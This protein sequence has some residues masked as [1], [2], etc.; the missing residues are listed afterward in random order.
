[1]SNRYARV[2][3]AAGAAVLVAALGVPVALA[4]GT[5]TVQPGG[6]IQAMSGRLAVKD[7]ATGTVVT[8]VSSSASG[9]LRN[10]SGLP[11]FHAGSL[12]AV[13]S[14]QCDGPGGPRFTLQAGGLPWHLNFT[15][16][17]AAKG[18]AQGTIGKIH[19]AVSGCASVIIDGTGATAHDGRV[20]F[21]YADSTGRLKVLTAGGNLHF[22]GTNGCLGLFGNGDPATF[23]ATYTV[24]PK[25]AI[26]S[27]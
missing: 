14:V 16:Y 3:T 26:T 7:T 25:Q 4:A 1:M 11:G 12:S 27:P 20:A 18:V 24:S 22:Y 15:T 21:R 6:G 5:W 2:L 23:S 19:I 13:S 8:C 17:N 9:T 10:G